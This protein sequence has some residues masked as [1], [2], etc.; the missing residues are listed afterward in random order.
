[1]IFYGIDGYN[2]VIGMFFKVRGYDY[3]FLFFLVFW[4]I[5]LFGGYEKKIEE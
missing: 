1:M 4:L 2:L 5:S 3:F